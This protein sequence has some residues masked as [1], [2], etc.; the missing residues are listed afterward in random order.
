MNW[1]EDVDQNVQDIASGFF[2]ETDFGVHS[3]VVML[4]FAYGYI[5]AHDV[6]RRE[7]LLRDFMASVRN[8]QDKLD[9]SEALDRLA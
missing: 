7:K 2:E 6:M 1:P 4:A 8:V 3:D 9:E 5:H